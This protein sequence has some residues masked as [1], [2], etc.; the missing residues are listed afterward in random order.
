MRSKEKDDKILKEVNNF[1]YGFTMYEKIFIKENS[2]RIDGIHSMENILN[3]SI[4]PVYVFI[5]AS[6][7]KYYKESEIFL[8]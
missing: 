1:Y 3:Q 4:T 6:V 5:N 2:K 8:L 7:K